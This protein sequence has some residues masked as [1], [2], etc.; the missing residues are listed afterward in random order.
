MP[1]DWSVSLGAKRTISESVRS[2]NWRAG[3]STRSSVGFCVTVRPAVRLSRRSSA[4]FSK[5]TQT[6]QVMSLDRS[7][8]AA[9]LPVAY[10]ARAFAAKVPIRR[11]ACNVKH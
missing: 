3:P 5:K 7:Q 6:Y 9:E 11:A 8:S 10:T 4:T 1:Q 2:V